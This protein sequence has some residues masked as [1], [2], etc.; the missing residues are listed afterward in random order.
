MTAFGVG[1]AQI[2]PSWFTSP[3]PRFRISVVTSVQLPAESCFSILMKPPIVVL[4]LGWSALEVSAV[5]FGAVT[6][7]AICPP[8]QP[9][10]DKVPAVLS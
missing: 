3:I 7:P 8:P 9:V 10:K 4:F 6:E 5:L 2:V 1:S